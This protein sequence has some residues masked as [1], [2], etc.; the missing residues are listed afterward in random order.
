H[1]EMR[2]MVESGMTPYQVLA[3]G[4]RKVAEFYGASDEYGSVAAGQRADLILLN[5][6]PLDDVAHVADR[7]GVMVKGRWLPE[8]EIQERLTKAVQ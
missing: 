2:V 8:S 4:T 3:S 1:R 5:A 6:N 7:A